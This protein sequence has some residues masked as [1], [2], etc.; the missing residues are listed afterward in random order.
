MGDPLI[1]VEAP[2]REPRRGGIKAI[3]GE[4]TP[5]PRLG[6]AANI[7]YLS[8]G[9]EWPSVAPGL[10][11]GNVTTGTKTLGGIDVET[12]IASVFGQYAGVECYLGEG[13]NAEYAA[14]AERQLRA[15][16][17][18][19][20]EAVLIGWAEAGTVSGTATTVAEAIAKAEE[21]ADQKYV[22]APVL[23]MSRFM[24]VLGAAEGVLKGDGKG[25]IWTI[26]G[27]PVITSWV[28]AENKITGIGW[29]TVYASE[30]VTNTAYNQTQNREMAI[31]ER[32]YALAVDCLFRG[33]ITV[34]LAAQQGE[35][36]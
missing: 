28:S 9:C 35:V 30:V 26:N 11:W 15:T 23:I 10:C 20:I 18:H 33:V 2:H 13:N 31:A 6:A 29:P 22:G 19:E 32:I 21:Y 17:E 4:F 3:T 34:T 27:T 25:E 1:T 36:G 16:E 12:G 7:Q 24:A 8:D 5:L 14:R